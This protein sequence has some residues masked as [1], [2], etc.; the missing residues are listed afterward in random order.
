MRGQVFAAVAGETEAGGTRALG[1]VQ[2]R[3]TCCF[4]FGIGD[5]AGV[6][7]PKLEGFRAR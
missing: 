2:Q 1:V 3:R 5:I 7:V 6:R 4:G